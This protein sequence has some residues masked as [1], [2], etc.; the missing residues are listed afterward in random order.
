MKTS[1]MLFFCLLVTALLITGCD[2]VTGGGRLEGVNGRAS[3]GFNADGCGIPDFKGQLQFNDH[4]GGQKF[5]GNVAFARQ[6]VVDGDCPVCDPLR[7][8]LGFPL[9]TGDYEVTI[10]YDS[11]NPAQPGSGLATVCLT[12][13]GEGANAV[14]S[15]NA[16]IQIQSGPYAPY[17][18][19]GPLRGNVQQHKCSGN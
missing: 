16:I 7:I 6:C 14:D 13:N 11:T 15:D 17:L 2:R 5:H 18:N 3:F 12:D 1:T 9:T 8:S 4:D 10:N 19:F